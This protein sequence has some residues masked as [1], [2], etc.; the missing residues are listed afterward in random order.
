ME[1]HNEVSW[2]LDFKLNKLNS[3]LQGK[4]KEVKKKMRNARL[5]QHV[6]GFFYS[7]DNLKFA[8]V[9][10]ILLLDTCLFYLCNR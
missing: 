2:L 3:E 1:Q 6:K 7:T 8:A 10:H 9:F 4:D 5:A